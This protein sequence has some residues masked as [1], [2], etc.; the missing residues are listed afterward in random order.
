M[1]LTFFP[2]PQLGIEAMPRRVFHYPQ[3][4][5]W[6]TLNLISSIGA[7]MIAFG[8]SIFLWNFFNSIV[9]GKGKPAGDDPWE[10]APPEW[11]TPS[12]PPGYNFSRLPVVHAAPP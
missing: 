3:A 4:P 7:F 2:Q 8:V 11:A 5:E 10:A 9:L 12:P 1:N 6:A